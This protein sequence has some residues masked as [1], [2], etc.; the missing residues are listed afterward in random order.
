MTH[1]K[2]RIFFSDFWGAFDNENNFISKILEQSYTIILDP[3]NPQYLFFSSFGY[4]HLTYK[5]CVKIYYTGENNVPDFNLCDYAMAFQ[6]IQ[7]EDRYFRYPV[8]ALHPG[9]DELPNKSVHREKALNRKFCNFVYTNS[10][11]ADPIREKI[12]HE[13]SKYKKVD[14]GGRLLNNIGKPVEDKIAFIENYKF[15]IA[16]ENSSVSGYT[17][18]KLIDPMRVNSMPIY[19]GNPRIEEDFNKNSFVYVN[20]FPHIEVVINEIIRLDKDDDAYLKKLSEPWIEPDK[21]K[22]WQ[23]DLSDF[24]RHIIEQPISKAKRATDYGFNKSYKKKQQIIRIF[25]RFS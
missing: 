14:S 13:L 21:I 11:A 18:E 4:K 22:R 5:N 9:F 1:K 2:I 8:Y 16:F 12:F 6:H 10:K 23:K 3:V 19:W 7:F 17:T 25:N 20:D 15:T 24:L